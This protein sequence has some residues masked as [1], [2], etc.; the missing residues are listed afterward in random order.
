MQKIASKL[1]HPAVSPKL[2]ADLTS[3]RIWNT[4]LRT[5]WCNSDQFR[6]IALINML[7]HGI[8]KYMWAHTGYNNSMAVRLENYPIVLCTKVEKMGIKVDVGPLLHSFMTHV[9]KPVTFSYAIGQ[10]A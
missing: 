2:K 4:I 7:R 9:D 6:I 8:A 1:Y 5:C 3:N 10:L